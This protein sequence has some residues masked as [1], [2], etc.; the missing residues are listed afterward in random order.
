MSDVRHKHTMNTN[1][2]ALP[3]ATPLSSDAEIARLA[4]LVEQV[5]VFAAVRAVS[6]DVDAIAGE[7]IP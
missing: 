7:C 3:P 1:S 6:E 5:P 4:A 2:P